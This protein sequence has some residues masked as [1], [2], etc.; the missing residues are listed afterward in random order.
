MPRSL[1]DCYAAM[2]P[3]LRAVEDMRLLNVMAVA[4]GTMDEKHR[5][6]WIRRLEADA[7]GVAPERQRTTL[8]DLAGM[9]VQVVT[10]EVKSA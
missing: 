4:S 7:Q 1:F 3:R 10:E 8:G 6:S 5:K 2:L 9:G